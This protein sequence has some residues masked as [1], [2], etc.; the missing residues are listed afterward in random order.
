MNS[1]QE[2]SI[3]KVREYVPTSKRGVPAQVHFPLEYNGEK[4][5]NRSQALQFGGH[6]Y[7]IDQKA[8]ALVWEYIEERQVLDLSEFQQIM[9]IDAK[10]KRKRQK[11]LGIYHRSDQIGRIDF[12]GSWA[13]LTAFP[14]QNS[15]LTDMM[16]DNI[17]NLLEEYFQ[18][19]NPQ[20][21]RLIPSD[22]N[23]DIGVKGQSAL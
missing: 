7:H 23:V 3:L 11:S 13:K 20:A 18:P 4:L 15:Q 9:K 6:F 19:D 8:M 2:L 10:T 14:S 16:I 17:I 1:N 21:E 12:T 22:K 5:D